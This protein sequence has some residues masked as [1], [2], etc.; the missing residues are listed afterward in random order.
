VDDLQRLFKPVEA[1]V[2]GKAECAILRFVIARTKAQDQPAI[3]D[4][5]D[6]VQHFGQQGRVPEA[7]AGDERPEFDARRDGRQR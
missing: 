1:M 3:A 2:E 4:L 6:R 7:C 5:L